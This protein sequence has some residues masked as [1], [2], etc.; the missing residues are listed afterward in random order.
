MT[1]CN[2]SFDLAATLNMMETTVVHLGTSA[3]EITH[4][5]IAANKEPDDQHVPVITQDMRIPPRALTA[6]DRQ[7][8]SIQHGAERSLF[9]EH[10]LFLPP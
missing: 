6:S 10:S 3:D 7:V 1:G 4:A 8:S 2:L 9:P 5:G